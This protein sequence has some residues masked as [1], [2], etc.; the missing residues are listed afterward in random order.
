MLL[1]IVE[2]HPAASAKELNTEWFVIENGSESSFSTK[3]CTLAV[4][5][6]NSKKKTELGTLDPG[7]PLAPG[8]RVR[9]ITGNP[10]RKAH[11]KAPDDDLRNYHL[12]LGGPVVRGSGTVLVFSL[13]S[14][15]LATAEFDPA[16]D[17]GV[18]AS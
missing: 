10:G 12:F 3:N 9:V 15:V 5:R 14:H 6:K 4:T 13:R 16:A 8:E 17:Q 1:K 11:G 2:I 7:F 18:A